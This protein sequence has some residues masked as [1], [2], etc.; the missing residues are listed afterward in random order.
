MTNEIKLVSNLKENRKRTL[1]RGT[2]EIKIDDKNRV[3][4]PAKL[5]EALGDKVIIYRDPRNTNCWRLIAS[6]E[7]DHWDNQI[8]NAFSAASTQG[9]INQQ[10]ERHL[11]WVRLNLSAQEE[12]FVDGQNRITIPK[13][14]RDEWPAN[15][16]MLIVGA[17]LWAEIW[18]A[19]AFERYKGSVADQ[20]T[21]FAP[22]LP[23]NSQSTNPAIQ[24][25]H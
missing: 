4:I 5:R 18:E 22:T 1:C 17:G 9:F 19:M 23:S 12:I 11:A 20:I 21:N 13:N 10:D 2:S 8:N 25:E 3:V 15:K 7:V 14:I 6:E 16:Q 24:D